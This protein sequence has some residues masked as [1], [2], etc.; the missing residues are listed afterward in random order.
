M[1]R[2]VA[3][4]PVDPDAFRSAAITAYGDALGLEPVAGGLSPYERE[5]LFEL[6]ERFRSPDW[7]RGPLQLPPPRRQVKIRA[8]VYVDWSDERKGILV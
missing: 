3:A 2:Y 8:G 5:Q 4:T 6:D 7:L 1:E